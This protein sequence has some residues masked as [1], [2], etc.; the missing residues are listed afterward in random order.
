MFLRFPDD[1][2]LLLKSG[3]FALTMSSVWRS[4]PALVFLPS[5]F[6]GPGSCVFTQNHPELKVRGSA[7]LPWA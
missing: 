4:A 7:G 5:F 6:E 2:R 3:R 1:L